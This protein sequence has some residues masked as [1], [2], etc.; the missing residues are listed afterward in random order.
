M[1]T[2]LS[3]PVMAGQGINQPQFEGTTG[4]LGLSQYY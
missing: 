3:L 1:L 4:R 2:I